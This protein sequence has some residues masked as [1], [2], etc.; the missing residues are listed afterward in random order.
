MLTTVRKATA[1]I[2]R[3]LRLPLAGAVAL[4]VAA[5][6]LTLAWPDEG[7]HLTANRAQLRRACG[8]LLPYGELAG[9]VP[10]AVRGK[11]DQYGT[12]LQ[13]G[14]ESRS[15]L[16]CTLDWQGHGGVHVEA[17]TLVNHLPYEL[18]TEDLLA[19]GHEV[20]GVTGRDSDDE[21]RLW[22]VAE[23][24][25]G[26][27]GRARPS[28]Q[29]YVSV[30]MDKASVRTRFRI[31][32][33]VAAGIAEREH[34]GSAAALRPP[35][36]VIDT[37]E[38]H[39]ADGGPVDSGDYGSVRVEE[40][41]RG[42]G[43]C[44][45]MT[46]RSRAGSAPLRGTWTATGDLQ[47]SRLLSVCRAERWNDDR[48][49]YTDPQ[50]APLEPVTADATSWA[51]D[52]GRSAYRDYERDGEYPGFDDRPDT[53][54]DTDAT[55]ALWAR[56]ECA[57]GPTYHR[58]SMRPNLDEAMDGASRLSRTQRTQM[59]THVRQL[60]KAYLSAP[61]GWPKAQHC[62]DTEVLGEVEQWT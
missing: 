35:T 41:G 40:P 19:P 16:N 21:G 22:V 23:C 44:R 24:P 53:L 9:R 25:A 33:E 2:P 27:T 55:L 4:A 13:P 48:S 34:C 57:A 52:L 39:D 51:G 31:A 36:R 50:P 37:Y 28:T 20:P 60:M 62:H 59:S 43:K 5:S 56:S 38:E 54:T 1:R 58:V 3:R 7:G 14:E 46:A 61:E 49:A 47:R 32:V 8:G 18:K 11:L 45:W 15:L 6:G 17:A 42:I 26:L 12:L 29:M 10:D 30:G